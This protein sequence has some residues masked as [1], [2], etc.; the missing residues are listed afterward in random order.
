MTGKHLPTCLVAA[1]CCATLACSSGTAVD[2]GEN[3]QI[4]R[5]G[6]LGEDG[7]ATGNAPSGSPRDGVDNDASPGRA[8]NG[9]DNSDFGTAPPADPCDGCDGLCIAGFC[10]GGG[11]T[12]FMPP[13]GQPQDEDDEDDEAQDDESAPETCG[14]D[15]EADSDGCDGD[16]DAD[17]HADSPDCDGTCQ[18]DD[19]ADGADC[20]G[21]CTD[22]EVGSSDC[23]GVC[24]AG[25]E[26]SLDCPVDCVVSEW[27]EW[28]ACSVACGGGTQTRT[29]TVTTE[30]DNGGAACPE[31]EDSGACNEQPCPIDCEV[32]AW[33]AWGACSVACGGG[34]QMRTRTVTVEPEHG[35][36]AC[37]EL[38]GTRECQPDPCPIDCQVSP[39]SDWGECSVSCGGGTQTRTRS[40]TV[41]P[42]NGGVMCPALESSRPCN[43]HACPVDCEVS[44]WSEWGDC[45]CDSGLEYR[46]R[47][48]TVEPKNGGAG[49][50]ALEDSRAC[51]EPCAP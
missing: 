50:P 8:G 37:P 2:I 39:W 3:A 16:C 7:G 46:I 32:S 11:G 9:G 23:D 1:L 12:G 24:D 19:D 22:A 15:A 36:A 33:T 47:S 21:T 29:R 31:L 41:E 25:E 40:V 17:D 51:V 35:G 43:T 10:L 44:D 45:D 48:V 18:S 4:G 42:S 28:S 26:D 27:A 49:C 6:G 5:D 20:D 30:A 38:E 14:E 34:T 13:G